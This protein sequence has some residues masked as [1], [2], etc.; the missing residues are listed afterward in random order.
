MSSPSFENRKKCVLAEALKESDAYNWLHRRILKKFG[1]EDAFQNQSQL[2]QT[3]VI[4]KGLKEVRLA[5][6]VRRRSGHE[7]FILRQAYGS[8]EEF[9]GYI[10][11][12]FVDMINEFLTQLPTTIFKDIAETM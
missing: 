11:Q 3:I 8:I 2:Y 6:Y 7:D 12:L 4:I 10:E 1:N 9:H 5:D